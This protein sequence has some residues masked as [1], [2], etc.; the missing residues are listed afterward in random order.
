MRFSNKAEIH[1]YLSLQGYDIGTTAIYR[2][3][4]AGKLGKVGAKTWTDKQVL[5]WAEEH[6]GHKRVNKPVAVTPAPVETEPETEPEPEADPAPEAKTKTVTIPAGLGLVDGLARLRAGEQQ[7][8][9]RWMKAIKEGGPGKREFD[10]W[11][12]ALDLLRKAEGSLLD[13]LERRRDLL[14]TDEVKK[15]IGRAVGEARAT[16]L[17]MPAKVAPS[18]DMRPW[19]EVQRTLEKEVRRACKLLSERSKL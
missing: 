15:H 3:T 17:E 7:C 5:A 12:A 6:F 1:R 16:L 2:A 11:A 9:G 10:S 14:S 4:K 13:L 19:T 18:L 8:F